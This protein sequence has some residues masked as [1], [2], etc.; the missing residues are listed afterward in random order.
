MD[1][2]AIHHDFDVVDTIAVERDVFFKVINFAVGA[3]ALK[4]RFADVLEDLLVLTFAPLDDRGKNLRARTVGQRFDFIDDLL[5][6]LSDD[7]RAADRTMRDADAR[8]QE[9]QIIVNL[10]NGAD[11]RAW[12]V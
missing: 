5:G 4:T 6:A 3:D 11:G 9:A 10:G 1:D 12:V 7:F 8:V 2:E